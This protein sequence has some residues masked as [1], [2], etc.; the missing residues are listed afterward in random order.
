M[1]AAPRRG[2]HEAQARMNFT[3]E[4]LARVAAVLRSN[5]KR[6]IALVHAAGLDPAQDLVGA[7]LQRVDFGTDNYAN[8]DFA[9]T[10]LH[11]ARLDQA[12]GLQIAGFEPPHQAGKKRN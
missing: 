1:Q 2:R 3:P 8:F 4:Q 12:R 9:C 5:D 7:D 10:D 11:G 6:F